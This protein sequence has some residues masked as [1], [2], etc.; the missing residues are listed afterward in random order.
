MTTARAL[1]LTGFG[2]NCEEEMAAA[3]RLAGGL[4]TI[5]HVNELFDGHV[6]LDDFDILNLPGGFSFGDDLGS[7][8]VLANRMRFRCLASGEPL[9]DAVRGFVARGGFVLG[10]CNGFQ[11]LVKMGLLPD[12]GGDCTQEVTLTRNDSGRFEDRWCEC[13]V[14]PRS[15]SPFLT[16]LTRLRLPVRHGEGKLVLRDDAVRKAIVER[17]LSCLSYCDPSGQPAT[18]FPDNPNGSELACAGLTDR[19]GRILG[20]MPHPEAF[21]SLYNDPTWPQ[22][23]RGGQ[24]PSEEGAG[25]SIFKNIVSHIAAMTPGGDR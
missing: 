9:F 2:I 25:M 15:R 21:L 12:V 5:T 7:G 11:A 4:A 8:K 23:K 10:I 14:N 19:T 3:Y 18:A 20:M 22:R 13:S 24:A 16:G 17:G 1:V 6:R